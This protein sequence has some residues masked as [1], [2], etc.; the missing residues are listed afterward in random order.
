MISSS[1]LTISTIHTLIVPKFVFI[2]DCFSKHQTQRA[3]YLSTWCLH[4]MSNRHLEL[5]MSKTVL[6]FPFSCNKSALPAVFSIPV[7]YILLEAQAKENSF[8]I[9]LSSIVYNQFMSK[10]LQ[11]LSFLIT[12]LLKPVTVRFLIGLPTF[13]LASL[14]PALDITVIVIGLLNINWFTCTL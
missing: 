12:S 14:W 3:N 1:H 6:H 11:N 9:R 5:N 10:Y 8:L 2:L 7:N 4:L 13:T